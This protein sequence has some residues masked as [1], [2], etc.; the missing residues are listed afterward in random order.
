MAT[1][2][3]G[4]MDAAAPDAAISCVPLGEC[5]WLDAYERHIVAALSGVEMV[6]PGTTLTQ[7]ASV[8]ARDATRTFL[9]TEFAALGLQAARQDYTSG[10]YVGANI[11]A[12]LEPT[13]DAGGT[14][15]LGAHFDTV[16]TSPGAADDGT[17]V[18]VVLAAA[19]YL[20]ELPVR[21]HRVVFALF[22]QEELGLIGSREYVKTLTGVSIRGAHIFDML[23]FDGDG[24]HVVELWSPSPALAAAYQA[25]AAAAG[26]PVSPVT[27][28]SSDHEAFLEAGL[29]ATGVSEEF[30]GGDHTLTYHDP[31][32]TYANVQFEYL[33]RA[34]RLALAVLDADVR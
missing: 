33:A 34:T 26:A 8:A 19:R 12:T 32:D 3:A 25:Q 10:N 28:S 27:F 15:I 14:I 16:P 30:V 23:S 6:V 1:P 31:S 11:V 24:D 29:V 5:A 18:A 13:A 2:D 9:I 4:P 7:R 20:R 21:H 17:G 22:D